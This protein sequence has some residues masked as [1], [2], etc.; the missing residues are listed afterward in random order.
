MIDRREGKQGVKLRRGG[1]KK[2][3]SD[4]SAVPLLSLASRG[5]K[6][7]KVERAKPKKKKGVSHRG[8]AYHHLLLKGSDAPLP[9]RKP[10]TAG[11]KGVG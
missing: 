7:K 11:A 9:K 1:K 10:K 6:K 3:G 2:E 8:R 5:K 4:R